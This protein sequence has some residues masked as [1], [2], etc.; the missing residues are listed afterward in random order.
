MRGGFKI[1]AQ[2]KSQ[3]AGAFK[4]CIESASSKEGAHL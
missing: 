2:P 1:Y 4:I 3:T